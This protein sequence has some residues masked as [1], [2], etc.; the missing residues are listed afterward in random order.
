MIDKKAIAA[1]ERLRQEF[2]QWAEQGRGEEMENHHISITQ[3]TLARMELKPG[4]RVLDLGCGAGWASRL[5]DRKSTRLNSSHLGISY[6]V[7]CL[8]R[9]PPRSTLFPYTTLFRSQQTLARMELKPGDR[10][11]DL[12]CGAGWASRLIADAVAHGDKPGQVIGLDVSD[13]MIRRARAGST[14]Y[15]NLMFVIG[16]AQQIPWE[17]NFFDKVLSVESFYYYRSEERRVGKE[18]RF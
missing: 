11:L 17:E 9:R 18:C 7:F 6:A 15:D 1:D 14:A 12:G 3:Q 16:S 2:N 8:M 13:E 5:I 10:V 4:D